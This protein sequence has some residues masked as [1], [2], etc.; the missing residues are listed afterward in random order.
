VDTIIR[1]ALIPVSEGYS[2]A[3]VQ[4]QSGAIAQIAP[5]IEATANTTEVSGTNHLLL[6][7]FVNGH[8]HSIQTWLRGL[9]PPLPL[10]LWLA[11][12]FDSTPNDLEYAYLGALHTAV[13]TLLSGGTYV[14][15]HLLSVPGQ[16]RETIAAV[17]RAYKEVGICAFIAPMLQDQSFASGFPN[18]ASL[19]HKAFPRATEEVLEIMEAI[20]QEFHDPAAGIHIAVGPTGFQRCSDALFEGCVEISDR[21]QLARHMHLL[22]TRSQKMLAHE[23]YGGSAVKHLQQLGMLNSRTSVAHGVW[24]EDEEIAILA[25]CGTTVVHNPTSNLRLGSGIA[26][27]L[28]YLK[29]GVNVAFGCDGAASNDGQNLLEAVKLGSILHNVT[30]FDYQHWITPRK[31]IEMAALGGVRGLGLGDRTG[32]LEAGQLAN[33]VLYDL[34]D[35]SLLPRTDPIGLLVLGNPK[36]VVSHAWVNGKAVIADGKPTTVDL[37]GLQQELKARSLHTKPQFQTINQFEAHYRR[38]MGL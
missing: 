7:G 31:A 37:D 6:P 4:I 25:E 1:Q 29:A 2:T 11:N 14:M 18:S 8:T 33:L 20:A 23:K 32:T 12:V 22:E 30:D 35:L 19:P 26:P 5:H 3:D 28:K 24:L 10:E 36:S 34:T 17:V 16:E 21:Y 9:I 13:N 27:V 15:D 38:V